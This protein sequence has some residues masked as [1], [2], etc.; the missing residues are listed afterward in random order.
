MTAPNREQDDFPVCRVDRRREI[1]NL[2]ATIA[3]QAP[4]VEVGK[5]MAE[6]TTTVRGVDEWPAIP[7]LWSMCADERDEARRKVAEQAAELESLR[8]D[9]ECW[10]DLVSHQVFNNKPQVGYAINR[11]KERVAAAPKQEK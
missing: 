1:R 7:T 3:E 8:K 6:L 4:F 10:R 9:A 11:T 5:A 2:E